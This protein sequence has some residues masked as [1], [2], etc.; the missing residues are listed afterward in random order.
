VTPPRIA[1]GRPLIPTR[2]Q[3]KN[4][5]IFEIHSCLAGL[6]DSAGAG[7]STTNLARGRV[8]IEYPH[9]LEHGRLSLNRLGDSQSVLF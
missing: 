2:R 1:N 8:L 5:F 7:L 9:S 6:N 3:T 4:I